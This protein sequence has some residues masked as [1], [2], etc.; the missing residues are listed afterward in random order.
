MAG[1]ATPPVGIGATIIRAM[2]AGSDGG[3]AITEAGISDWAD[4]GAPATS[5]KLKIDAF[6]PKRR[7][8]PLPFNQQT[9]IEQERDALNRYSTDC[10]REAT[11]DQSFETPAPNE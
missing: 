11:K 1:I 9:I 3:S 2:C 5:A 8:L 4:K 6:I 7:T 10:C